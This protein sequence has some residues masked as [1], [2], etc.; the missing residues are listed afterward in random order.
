MKTISR[1][2]RFIFRNI[3]FFIGTIR[4]KRVG[5]SFYPPN[6]IYFDRFDSNSIV[7]DVGCAD[8]ADYSMHMINLYSCKCFGVDPTK[9]HADAL[10]LL[11]KKH[12][13]LFHHLPYAVS[14]KSGKITFHESSSNVSGSI[15]SD[16]VN[17]LTDKSISYEIEAITINDLKQKIGNRINILKLD[18]EGAEYALFNNIEQKDIIDIDQIFVEFHHHCIDKYSITDTYK[19][20]SILKNLGFRSFTID[21]HNYLF[22]KKV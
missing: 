1:I 3:Y 19:I 4:A 7:V 17:I 2:I 13:G 12:N 18:L 16:H 15:L 11:E 8:D 14:N 5:L 20:V 21:M 9:K 10:A 22:Y 6:F